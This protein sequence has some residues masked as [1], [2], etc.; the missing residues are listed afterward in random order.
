MSTFFFLNKVS[1]YK[2]KAWMIKWLIWQVEEGGA[3]SVIRS[4]PTQPGRKQRERGVCWP[5]TGLSG[6]E[7]HE[8]G[9]Q[10]VHGPQH[11]GVPARHAG[12]H[13]A[14]QGLEA[15]QDGRRLQDG[16]QEAQHFQAGADVPVVHLV[17]LLLQRGTRARCG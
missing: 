5:R 3:V 17:R 11:L 15:A 9:Q 10:A 1:R 16:E 12:G 2:K 6:E 4:G 7:A 13:A 8:A 14:L